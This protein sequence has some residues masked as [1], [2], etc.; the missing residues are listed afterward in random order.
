MTAPPRLELRSLRKYFATSK[1]LAVDGVSLAVAPGE[2][3]A[4]I[5]ENGTGKTTLMNLVFGVHQPDAGEIRVDG[6]PVRIS[7]PQA[8]IEHGV[9]MV[10]QHFELVP[11]FTVAQNVLLGREP[12]RRGRYDDAEAERRVT[13]LMARSGL[14][15]DPRRRVRDLPVAAQQRVEILKALARDARVLILD[16]PTAVLTPQEADELIVLVRGLA[17]A[18]RSVV[19]ISHKLPE[20]QEVADR[21]V[22]M[23]RG[24][25]VGEVGRGGAD[26]A[27]LA[28]L[29]VGRDVP[30]TGSYATA[31][32]GPELLRVEGAAVPPTLEGGSGLRGV[33]LALRSGEILGIAGVGGNG[34]DEL[35]D[36]VTGLGRLEGGSVAV[37]GVDIT[38]ATPAETRRRGIA[39]IAADR[40]RVG[41]NLEATLEENAVST[42]FRTRRFS[43][44]GLIRRRARRRFA[45]A[46]IADY[47]VR[48]AAPARPVRSL[49]GGNLQ[50]IV[51]GRELSGN[52][53]VVLANQPTRGLDVGSI[54]FV[55]GALSRARAQGAGVLLVSAELD[56][57]MALS[58]RIAVMYDG[59]LIGPFDRADVDRERLGRLMAGVEGE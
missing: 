44:A 21:V 50:K 23:R 33:D 28:R 36:A 30:V 53:R 39:H 20:V 22:V 52:P 18:G 6:R 1:V 11:G 48:G 51:I 49:S 40:M 45:A 57:V 26:D 9:A 5:G 12:T 31:P 10:H 14:V 3:V 38:R 54:E 13:E 37:D 24:R 2:V 15:L 32:A 46:L 25:I 27:A 35:I 42:A 17:A 43:R 41:L 56:E 29:M 19:F 59:R 7:G 4:L 58:D 8:A 55:H 16:E 47:E 34:Q